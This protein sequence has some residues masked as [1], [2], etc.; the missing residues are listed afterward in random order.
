[1][2]G[3]FQSWMEDEGFGWIRV[4]GGDD[5]WV[6]FSDILRDPIRFPNGYRFLK[7]GQL[8][9]FQLEVDPR[10]NEQARKAIHVKIVT[11]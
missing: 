7:P 6:H 10:L 8:V 3:I 9:E 4:E 5:V 2:K 11:E 1:M